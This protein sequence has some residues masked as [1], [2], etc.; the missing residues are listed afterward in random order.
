MNA[1]TEVVDSGGF[2][3]GPNVSAFEKSFAEYCGA[4]YALGV[5]SGTSALHLASKLLNLGP[6]DEVITTPYTFA[7]TAWAISYV[8]AKPVFVDIDEATF[9]IDPKLV[10]AAITP[11]TKAIIAVHLYGHP[12]DMDT[13]TSLCKQHDISLIE[14]AAQSHG[15]KFNGQAVGSFGDVGCL[16]FTQPKTY[17]H[18]AKVEP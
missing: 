5:N 16:V 18:A 14:D 8:G 17:P 11:K 15:A 10:E 4:N 2:I 6:G 12:C 9:N 7:A 3:L 13:L 1:I